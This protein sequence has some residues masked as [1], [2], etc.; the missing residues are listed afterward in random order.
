M[1]RPPGR[2]LD[3]VMWTV[4][5]TPGSDGTLAHASVARTVAGM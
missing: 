1:Q 3:D 4:R 5:L 2:G